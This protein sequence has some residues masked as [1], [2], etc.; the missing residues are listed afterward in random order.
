MEL[1]VPSWSLAKLSRDLCW[2]LVPHALPR[3]LY[4]HSSWVSASHWMSSS[5]PHPHT[6]LTQPWQGFSSFLSLHRRL[7]ALRTNSELLDSETGDKE[8]VVEV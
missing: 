2:E 8:L 4:A 1:W 6:H 7:T 5:A 3:A